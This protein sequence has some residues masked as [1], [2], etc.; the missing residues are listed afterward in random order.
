[1]TTINHY[2]C[3]GRFLIVVLTIITMNVSFLSK[4]VH[5][6]FI[7]TTTLTS[8]S[9]TTLT[10]SSIRR[11]NGWMIRNEKEEIFDR[12]SLFAS[13]SNDDNTMISDINPLRR[14]STVALCTPYLPNGEIDTKS[15]RTLLQY[16]VKSETDGLCILGTTGEASL[17]SLA[18][19]Q[20]ILD[21]AVEEA[22][23]KIPLM[24]GVGAVNPS[25]VKEATI[26]AVNS[27]ADAILVVSPPYVK[28]P[29]HGL[30]SFFIEIAKLAKDLPVVLYNVP[31]RTGVDVLPETIAE[32]YIKQSNIVAVKEA[33]GDVSRVKDIQNA[34]NAAIAKAAANEDTSST[35]KKKAPLLLYS[36]DDSTSTEF[37][38]AG[39]DGCISVTANVAPKPMHDI[40]SLALQGNGKQAH[41]LN[42]KLIGL[43]ESLFCT[44]SPVPA[45][46]A[47]HKIGMID[48]ASCRSPLGGELRSEYHGEVE[49][50]LKR[51]SLI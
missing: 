12:S 44:S 40:M 27:G 51:A 13:N 24:I 20:I 38:L 43:H 22:K 11:N 1:M 41:E 26:Q 30:V 18:E 3:T 34:C 5:G 35:I 49:D 33:T 42:D 7:T 14:G 25:D 4:V 46:W 10:S 50:A 39:G 17:L 6:S 8:T 2:Q 19:R 15:L 23:H 9:T 37:V 31:S 21:I 16:H 45:K 48:N 36:G 47:L 32:C 28:P 29:Q